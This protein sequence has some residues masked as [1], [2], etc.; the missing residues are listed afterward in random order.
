MNLSDMRF[1]RQLEADGSADIIRGSLMARTSKLWAGSSSD[2]PV[3]TLNESMKAVLKQARA[4]GRIRYGLE[5]ILQK[6][7]SEKT[8]IANVRGRS[9]S[10]Y[11]DRLSRLLLVSND[12]AERLYRNIEQVLDAHAPRLL[13]CMLDID[14]AALGKFFTDKEVT[15]KIVMAEHKDVLSDILRA[16][17]AGDRVI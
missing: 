9:D 6:L 10:P 13:C 3:I 4:R 17:V 12:G 5:Q 11:G 7:A 2:V 16:M 15:I 14:S 8:G 1:P